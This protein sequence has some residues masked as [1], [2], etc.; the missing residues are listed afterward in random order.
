MAT[1]TIKTQLQLDSSEYQNKI[2]DAKQS[3][4]S[5]KKSG[6]LLS[7]ALS[8]F[9]GVAGVCISSMEAFNR[10]IDSSQTIG[11]R[12]RDWETIS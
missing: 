7:G 3:M 11:R 4:D 12:Y 2:K 8:K 9:A 1:S 5:F 10:V 6:E